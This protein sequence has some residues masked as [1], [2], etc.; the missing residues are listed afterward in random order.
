MADN[1][2]AWQREGNIKINISPDVQPFGVSVTN[3][4]VVC[5]GHFAPPER[6]NHFLI[7]RVTVVRTS[8]YKL[9]SRRHYELHYFSLAHDCRVSSGINGLDQVFGAASLRVAVI[10]GAM[11]HCLS[12]SDC[13]YAFHAES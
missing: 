11:I 1:G 13:C 8:R 6:M 5:A 3:N 2:S 7:S 12:L 10:H 4:A 9:A